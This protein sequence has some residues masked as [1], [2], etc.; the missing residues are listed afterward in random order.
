MVGNFLCPPGEVER[1]IVEA[2]TPRYWAVMRHFN[3]VEVIE[4]LED[5]LS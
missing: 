5:L 2:T 3:S 1:S 4:N